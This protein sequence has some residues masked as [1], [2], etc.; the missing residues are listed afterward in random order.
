M[1]I[2]KKYCQTPKKK[3]RQISCRKFGKFLKKQENVGGLVN[4]KFFKSNLKNI[5][6]IISFFKMSAK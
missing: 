3:A 1:K 5:I 4:L 6:K 2:S